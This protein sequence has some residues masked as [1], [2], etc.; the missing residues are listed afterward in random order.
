MITCQKAGCGQAATHALQIGCGT[1]T[2]P[3]EAP[4]RARILM[5]I[6]LCEPC[7]DD[8]TAERWLEINPALGQLLAVAMAGGPPPDLARAVILGV[9]LDSAEYRHLQLAH[10]D[11]R[12]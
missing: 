11:Q 1:Y 4:P 9:S 6:L 12:N 5:G 2:D 3:E 7:L 8:E 10:L